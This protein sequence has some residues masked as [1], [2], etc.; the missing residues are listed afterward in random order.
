MLLTAKSFLLNLLLVFAPLSIM[1]I[2]YLLKYT[3]LLKRSS[4]WLLALFPLISVIL[5]MMYPVVINDNFI[6]DFRRIPFI[7]GALYGGKWVGLIY[8]I[9]MLSYR[10]SLGGDGFY[11]TLFSFSLVTVATS[12]V[13]AHFLN[14]DLKKKLLVAAAMDGLV[15]IVSTFVSLTFFNSQ[16]PLSMWILFSCISVIGVVLATLIYEVFINQFKLLHSVMEGQKLKVVSH[17]AASISH[18]V[19]NPLTVSRGFLQLIDSDLKDREKKGYMK[20]AINELD[21]ATEIINDY[22]TF[23]KPYPES[24]DRIDIISEIKHSI[25]VIQP[26]ASMMNVSIN[27]KID[28][29][30]TYMQSE[31]RKFQQCLLNISKNAIEAMSEGGTLTIQVSRNENE[32]RISIQDTGVGMTE[33]QLS[34]IGE[35]FF[36]TKEKGTGLGMM[37]SHSIVKAMGGELLYESKSGQGTTVHLAFQVEEM[38]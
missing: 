21:R 37:V 11:P 3:N 23:A 5:C 31:K 26:L 32:L 15:G 2:L 16:I 29:P 13:S 6:L 25:S 12:I 7:L 27:S 35:P 10:F 38:G 18:E 8:L 22:L 9:V 28:L 20:L 30:P 36:T 19:R 1:Q 17:L 14:L 34:R 33:E 4:G 24:V